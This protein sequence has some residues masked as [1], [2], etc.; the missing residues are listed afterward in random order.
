MN[1][2]SGTPLRT[3]RTGGGYEMDL[4]VCSVSATGPDV[5][6]LT[7]DYPIHN[8]KFLSSIFVSQP[9]DQCS[10]IFAHTDTDLY[11]DVHLKNWCFA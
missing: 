4:I 9:I 3:I 7:W 1:G 5:E 2:S 11:P 6:T 8:K 10:V